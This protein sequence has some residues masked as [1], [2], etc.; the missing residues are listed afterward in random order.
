MDG[1][2]SVGRLVYL[3]EVLL[4]LGCSF[5]T[6]RRDIRAGRL[7]AP[8]ALGGRV[9]WPEAEVARYVA[10]LPEARPR[11]PGRP[12]G[13]KGKRGVSLGVDGGLVE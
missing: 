12:R 5:P 9:C 11:G 3:D 13:A 1:D 8:R 6:L 4:R 2:V 10:A 7:A